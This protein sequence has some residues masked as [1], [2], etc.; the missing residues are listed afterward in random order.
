[1]QS[2]LET[3]AVFPKMHSTRIHVY[4][5]YCV[6]V[7]GCVCTSTHC[8]LNAAILLSNEMNVDCM[9]EITMIIIATT[10]A[11]QNAHIFESKQS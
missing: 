4:M 1:M 5:V 8:S 6:W 10:F 3:I 2:M 11:A 7:G 9:S